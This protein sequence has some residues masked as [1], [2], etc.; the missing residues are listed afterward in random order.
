MILAVISICEF[1]IIMCLTPLHSNCHVMMPLRK[2]ALGDIVFRL[3]GRSHLMQ[4]TSD[5]YA[6]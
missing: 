6:V 2:K 5:L 4:L 1:S 3:R